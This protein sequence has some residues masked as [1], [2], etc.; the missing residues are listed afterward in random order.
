MQKTKGEKMKLPLELWIMLLISLIIIGFLIY[1][2]FTKPEGCSAK[3]PCV[4]E[5]KGEYLKSILIPS[6]II[7][8]NKTVRRE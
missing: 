8:E 1:Q 5:I 7:L 4:T 6:K 2:G 3:R